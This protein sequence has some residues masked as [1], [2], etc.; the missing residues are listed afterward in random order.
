MRFKASLT[1]WEASKQVT[2]S[3]D[4]TIQLPN[5][6]RVCV[7]GLTLD[8]IEREVNL[9]YSQQL[10]QLNVTPALIQL[11]AKQAFVSGEVQQAGP[12]CHQWADDS[13]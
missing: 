6:G 5:I 12:G 1:P 7:Y 4:G 9:R 13:A 11:S 8:E 10:S 3:P 2:V